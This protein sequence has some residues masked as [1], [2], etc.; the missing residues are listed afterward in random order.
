M[1]STQIAHHRQCLSGVHAGEVMLCC[2][3]GPLQEVY[4][5][6]LGLTPKD[7]AAFARADQG[8]LAAHK[9][10]DM[11]GKGEA[12][13]SSDPH[14]LLVQRVQGRDMCVGG[15]RC[16]RWLTFNGVLAMAVL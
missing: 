4:M 15:P 6:S 14:T 9:W 10:F 16:W 7:Y 13:G 8:V 3:S 11:A 5:R 12:V 2:A 1:L